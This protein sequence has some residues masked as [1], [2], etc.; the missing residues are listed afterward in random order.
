MYLFHGTSEE[1]AKDIIK[2]GFK[3][4]PD[5]KGDKSV[6]K[7]KKGPFGDHYDE[8]EIEAKWEDWYYFLGPVDFFSPEPCLVG[9][10]EWERKGSSPM[11]FALPPESSKPKDSNGSLIIIK[12]P[13]EKI[14]EAVVRIYRSKDVQ[15][16]F[17]FGSTLED[18]KK[19]FSKLDERR[20]EKAIGDCQVLVDNNFVNEFLLFGFRVWNGREYVKKFNPK[21]KNKKK[22]KEK[23]KKSLIWHEVKT[24]EKGF[25]GK[26]FYQEYK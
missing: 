4:K 11:K 6:I 26:P 10:T 19:R 14:S 3:N 2:D 8:I 15:K 22:H 9:L 17:P 21:Y 13:S 23:N 5:I 1:N 25:K 20:K 12:I 7:R 16:F 24:L 18:M